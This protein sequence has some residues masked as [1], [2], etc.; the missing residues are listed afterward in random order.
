MEE[1]SFRQWQENKI[2]QQID[3]IIS[4]LIADQNNKQNEK[5]G[6]LEFDE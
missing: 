1:I 5:A 2:C 3:S 6:C 4:S